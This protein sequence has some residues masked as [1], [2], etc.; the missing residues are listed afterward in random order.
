LHSELKVHLRRHYGDKP[1]TCNACGKGFV[2][3]RGIIIHLRTLTGDK[4]YECEV[5]NLA[6]V[7]T[8]AGLLVYLQ[9]RHVERREETSGG[10]RVV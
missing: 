7:R 10:E 5:S 8:D 9:H 2:T 6:S 4:P 1:W 3:K